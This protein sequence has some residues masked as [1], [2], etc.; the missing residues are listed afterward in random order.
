V[1]FNFFLVLGIESMASGTQSKHS[2]IEPHSRPFL[3]FIV[4]CYQSPLLVCKHFESKICWLLYWKSSK[5]ER[6]KN[7]LLNEWVN[8]WTNRNYRVLLNWRCSKLDSFV[9]S[10][11][12]LWK[13]ALASGVRIFGKPEKGLL[14]PKWRQVWWGRRW[15]DKVEIFQVGKWPRTQTMRL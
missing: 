3:V 9:R 14:G 7:Y 10:N 4:A 5:Q 13:I 12:H 8:E 15:K 6:L 2:T 1:V 11:V